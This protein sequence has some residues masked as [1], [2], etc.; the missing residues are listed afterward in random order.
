MRILVIDGEPETAASCHRIFGDE[1]EVV[2]ARTG[3]SALDL[4][5][6]GRP[7]DIIFCELVLP[8]MTGIEVHRRLI[9]SSPRSASRIIF[10]T[11]DRKA[12]A[13]FLASVPNLNVDKPLVPSSLRQAV[14][15]AGMR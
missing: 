11:D 10:V 13:P 7:F 6:I 3:F 14:R 8:D 2:E 15:D 9:D 5:A 1:H 4:L 12:N